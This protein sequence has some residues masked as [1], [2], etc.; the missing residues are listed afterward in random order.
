MSGFCQAVGQS[1]SAIS[2]FIFAPIFG[3]DGLKTPGGKIP[4]DL[5]FLLHPSTGI[6]ETVT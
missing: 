3:W 2:R 5:K 1:Q 4:P 6:T